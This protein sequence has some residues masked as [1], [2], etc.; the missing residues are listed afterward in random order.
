MQ[1]PSIAEVK[2]ILNQINDDAEESGQH[3][4]PFDDVVYYTNQIAII[5]ELDTQTAMELA[6]QLTHS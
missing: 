6:E 3:V 1:P 5:W 4:V 2:A